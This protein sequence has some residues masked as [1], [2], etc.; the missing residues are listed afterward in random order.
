[1]TN[2]NKKHYKINFLRAGY[3]CSQQGYYGTYEGAKEAARR[4]SEMTHSSYLI[5]QK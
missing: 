3:V 4:I 1:M 2:I 5:E